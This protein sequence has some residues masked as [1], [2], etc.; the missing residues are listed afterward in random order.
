MNEF[1][2]RLAVQRRLLQLV[3]AKYGGKEELFGLSSK[4]IA[5]WT[6]V[7]QIAP[8]DPLVGL[9]RSAS[10]RLFFLANRSQEQISED[11]IAKSIEIDQ[12]TEEIER[13]IG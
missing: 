10:E 2:N 11:Y 4:A 1:N 8:D 12:L 3:N 7:N 6:A 5:R 9:I 13:V